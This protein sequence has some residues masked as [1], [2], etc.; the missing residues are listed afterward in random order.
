MTILSFIVCLQKRVHVST[1]MPRYGISKSSKKLLSLWLSGYFRRTQALIPI[2]VSI[3]LGNSNYVPDVRSQRTSHKLSLS[4]V[5]TLKLQVMLAVIS[6]GVG[7]VSFPRRYEVRSPNFDSFVINWACSK[8]FKGSW[9]YSYL[10]YDT[11]E[12][13]SF[14]AHRLVQSINRTSKTHKAY[15]P[16]CRTWWKNLRTWTELRP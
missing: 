3:N 8:Q 2:C 4:Q 15:Y 14:T 7:I 12:N 13:D 16:R 6:F 10:T 1:Q 11:S 9:T 5:S